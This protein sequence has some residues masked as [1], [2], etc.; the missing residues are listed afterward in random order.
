M[1]KKFVRQRW[2]TG[3]KLRFIAESWDLADEALGRFLRQ[4][5]LHSHDLETWKEQM[6]MGI[7][8]EKSVYLEERRWYKTKIK[9]LEKELQEAQAIIEL[10]KKVKNLRSEAEDSKPKSKPEKKSST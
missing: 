3:D 10:Q 9:R 4:N 5:G 6:A 1:S 8:G 7:N 2:R